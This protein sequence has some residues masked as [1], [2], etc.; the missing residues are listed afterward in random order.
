MAKKK[1]QAVHHTAPKPAPSPVPEPVKVPITTA[2]VQDALSGIWA[3]DVSIAH[4]DHTI[5]R[6]NGRAV[7]QG[8]P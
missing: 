8:S 6:V 4:G 2:I 1:P 5:V 7:W 3:V